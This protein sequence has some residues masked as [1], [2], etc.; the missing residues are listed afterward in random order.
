MADVRKLTV[1]E[2]GGATGSIRVSMM[3]L[4]VPPDRLLMVKASPVA[5]LTRARLAM[6]SLAG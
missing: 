2:D 4:T 6:F 5:V 3:K 1:G